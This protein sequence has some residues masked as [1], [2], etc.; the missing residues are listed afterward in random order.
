MAP[1][2]LLLKKHKTLS[3]ELWPPR[4][5]D[6]LVKLESSLSRLGELEIDF[7][8]ITYGAGGSTRDRTH[9]LVVKIHR[10]QK[11]T[12]MAHLTCAYHTR[13]ELIDI[14]ERYKA[15]GIE[16]ILALRG[17]PPVSRKGDPIDG[18]LV[19]AKDLVILAKEI[20][21]F[22]VAVAAHPTGHPEAENQDID[23]RHLFD[24]LQVA[25]FAI[26]QLF[27][28]VEQYKIFVDKLS[29]LGNTKP[30]LPGIMPIRNMKS[31]MTMSRLTDQ[32]VPSYIYD[33]VASLE[34]NPEDIRI[35]GIDFA[36]QMSADLLEM[37]VP[38]L[39]FYTMN[40][41]NA[42]I[43]ICKNLNYHLPQ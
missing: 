26:T 22:V 20:G 3:V 36:T 24:K 33:K 13:G 18:D 31:L 1:I 40:E 21:N 30:I 23:V 42:T 37:D 27:F 7:A 43:E 14:L 29:A 9:D 8:S 35:F 41:T 5:E 2:D 19:F 39:H 15:E 6:A 32:E 10:Q 28:S 4:T 12:P 11:M 16:N 38:G 34:N 17:D 25:D